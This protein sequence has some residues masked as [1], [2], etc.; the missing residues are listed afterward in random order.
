MARQIFYDRIGY[1]ILVL[2]KRRKLTRDALAKAANI[3]WNE[4][5]WI[6]KEDFSIS[7][8]AIDRIAAVLEV[9]GEWLRYYKRSK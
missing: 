9:D 5:L 4:L 8:E 6:E 7:E 3:S 1:R 2:R